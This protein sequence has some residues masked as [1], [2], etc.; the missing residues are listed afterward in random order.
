MRDNGSHCLVTVDC[1][2]FKIYEPSPWSAK[3]FSYKENHAGLRYEL[4]ICIQTG[5]I[6][7]TNGPYAPGHWPDLSISRDSLCD[8][9]DH[10]EL[11]LADGTYSDGHGWC[12][13]PTYNDP[14]TPDDRMK[15]KARAYH[16]GVNGL[17]KKFHVLGDCFRHH[18]TKHGRVFAAV[19]N[20]VQAKI[21][22]EKPCFK[23]KYKN[24]LNN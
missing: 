20:I 16:E 13:T 3:W 12:I 21:Q 2:D 1:T 15:G 6:V 17:L 8:A 4:G 7:W 22:L 23:V 24:D 9:L 19:A 10:G 14:P 5:W 18:R 11:F